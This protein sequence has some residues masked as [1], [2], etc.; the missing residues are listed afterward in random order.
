MFHCLWRVCFRRQLSKAPVVL[1]FATVVLLCCHHLMYDNAGPWWIRTSLQSG[2]LNLTDLTWVSESQS[3]KAL[4]FQF[5]RKSWPFPEEWKPNIE[6]QEFFMNDTDTDQTPL[7][8]SL[9]WVF[10][11]GQYRECACYGKI[12]WGTD[13]NWVYIRP[14][15]PSVALRIKC[16]IGKQPGVPE[17]VDMKPG[18]DSK[19]CECQVNTSTK[20]FKSI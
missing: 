1:F 13:Q 2:I 15:I 14:S 19:H 9:L 18:D 7:A 8:T 16:Q 3:Q 5:S 17:L 4:A 11:S 6:F 20:F 12:R 10:C